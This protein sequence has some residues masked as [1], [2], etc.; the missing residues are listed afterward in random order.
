MECERLSKSDIRSRIQKEK[1]DNFYNIE[2]TVFSI[3]KKSIKPKDTNRL[4]KV[5]VTNM[6]D[7]GLMSLNAQF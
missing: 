7:K 1:A 2:M 6:V 3:F 5:N 4:E